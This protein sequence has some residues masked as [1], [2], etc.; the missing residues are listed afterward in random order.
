MGKFS[1]YDWGKFA[2]LENLSCRVRS[3]CR[4]HPPWPEGICTKCQPSP[5]TLEIQPYRHVDYVQFENG[6]I[7]ETFLDFWR[8]TGRQRIGLLLGRYAHFD[9]A[10]SPPLAIKAVV[11]AI[12]EPAQ[13]STPRSVKLT[14]P[15]DALMPKRTVEV[16]RRLGLRPVGWIFTDLVAEEQPNRGEVQ[17]FRGTMYQSK[18]KQAVYLKGMGCEKLHTSSAFL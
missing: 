11:A 4:D 12:Y 15:L 1:K 10:G 3:G 9:T 16:A 14:D 8:Q 6:Q 18:A 13:E 17:H 2:S 7:M 5:V